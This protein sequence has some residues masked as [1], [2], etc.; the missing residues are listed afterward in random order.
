MNTL[1][2][3]SFALSLFIVVGLPV[4]YKDDNAK[5]RVCDSTHQLRI[6]CTNNSEVK[7]TIN[8]IKNKRIKLY[9]CSVNNDC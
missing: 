7:G 4:V 2:V 9:A 6:G 3:F 8:A 1:M 5:Q